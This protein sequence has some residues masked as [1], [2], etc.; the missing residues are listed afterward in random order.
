MFLLRNV[1]S[2]GNCVL[3]TWSWRSKLTYRSFRYER[4]TS[5][6][7]EIS[8]IGYNGSFLFTADITVVVVANGWWNPAWIGW[9]ILQQNLD[10]SNSDNSSSPLTPT[11]FAFPWS[12]FRWNLP[13]DSNNPRFN[14]NSLSFTFRARVTRPGSY[15]SYENVNAMSIVY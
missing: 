2:D 7:N 10:N 1:S 14:S 3:K 5:R 12:K 8:F 11:K 13:D 9:Q 15:F 6:C 4:K